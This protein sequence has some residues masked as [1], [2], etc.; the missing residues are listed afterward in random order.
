MIRRFLLIFLF[1]LSVSFARAATYDVVG[2]VRYGGVVDEILVNDIT[3]N[4]Y[5]LGDESV[6]RGTL[7]KDGDR[8]NFGLPIEDVAKNDQIIITAEAQVG[9]GVKSN[10]YFGGSTVVITNK[11]LDSGLIGEVTVDLRVI[12]VPVFDTTDDEELSMC[13]KGMDDFSV[14]SYEVYR[15]NELVGDWEVVGRAGQNANKQV[16]F[17]DNAMV[18]GEVYYY[19]IAVLN[20]WNAGVGKEAYVSR[21]R[22]GISNGVVLNKGEVEII[23]T[24]KDDISD[25]TET[26]VTKPVV[27]STDGQLVSYWDQIDGWWDEL[28]AIIDGQEMSWQNLM[29]LVMAGIL[30]VIILYFVVSVWIANLTSRGSRIWVEKLDKE[31]TK[32]K[33][34]A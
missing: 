2:V 15:S 28:K 1:V 4:V 11:E 32:K 6:W 23:Q 10:G 3:V 29:I 31:K 21:A 16:C 26:D 9:A 8:L 7:S 34:S 19:Q 14:I 12:P 33:K 13:W 22:S 30:L 20:S 18:D 24:D 5:K 25:V 27:D 17:I